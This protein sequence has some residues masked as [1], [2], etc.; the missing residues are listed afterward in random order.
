LLAEVLATRRR[1]SLI[2]LNIY[3]INKRRAIKA[4][5]GYII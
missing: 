3:N 1:N 5:E 4:T 2:L